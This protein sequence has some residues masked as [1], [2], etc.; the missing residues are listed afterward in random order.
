[1]SLVWST[2]ASTPKMGARRSVTKILLRTM[3]LSVFTVWFHVFAILLLMNAI[4][5]KSLFKKLFNTMKKRKMWNCF[6]LIWKSTFCKKDLHKRTLSWHS[7]DKNIFP[8][9]PRTSLLQ[10]YS[11]IYIDNKGNK[12]FFKVLVFWYLKQQTRHPIISRPFIV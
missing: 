8:K 2:I 11:S 7:T 12:Q 3:S 1:M 5:K 10:L 9:K 4:V 6:L